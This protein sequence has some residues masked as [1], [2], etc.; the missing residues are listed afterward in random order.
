PGPRISCTGVCRR[1]S[2]CPLHYAAQLNLQREFSSV[3]VGRFRQRL[4]TLE[5]FAVVLL[6]LAKGAPI[7]RASGRRFQVVQR[8]RLVTAAA[9]VMREFGRD[10]VDALA[11]GF[12]LP[13]GDPSMQLPSLSDG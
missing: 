9:I 4:Y 11:V 10:L 2:S 3:A 8:L 5:R 12:F 13:L 7:D 1:P 6:G